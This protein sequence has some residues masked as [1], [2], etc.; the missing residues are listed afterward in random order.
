[1]RV[2]VTGA[3]GFVGSA[4]VE[5]L[6]EARHQV[7]ERAVSKPEKRIGSVSRGAHVSR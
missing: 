4:V 2:F 5:D 3:T 7:V 6:I 1:M